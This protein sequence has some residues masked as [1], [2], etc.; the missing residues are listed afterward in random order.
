[1]AFTSKFNDEIA[2]WY[3]VDG[4]KGG[5]KTILIPRDLV[6]WECTIQSR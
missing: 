2:R 3:Y 1:M 6:T 4:K 5:K